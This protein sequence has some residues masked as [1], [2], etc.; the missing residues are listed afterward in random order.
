MAFIIYDGTI[1]LIALIG[2]I[3]Q[4]KRILK[5][6]KR[7][8]KGGRHAKGKENYWYV[9]KQKK[10]LENEKRNFATR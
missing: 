8:Y 5:N 7:P 3:I 9:L 4:R 6:K 1:F 10:E 2:S